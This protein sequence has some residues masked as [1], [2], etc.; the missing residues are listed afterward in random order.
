[1]E[2]TNLLI[3]LLPVPPLL[4][5][6]IILLFA[7]RSNKASWMI[8]VGAAALSFIGSMVVFFQA[9]GERTSGRTSLW[10]RN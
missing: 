5:F 2:M 9:I 1:M 6:F 10:Q 7:N 3:W 8:G 4:A